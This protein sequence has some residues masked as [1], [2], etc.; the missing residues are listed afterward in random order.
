[1]RE[2]V[3]HSEVVAPVVVEV[4]AGASV[5]PKAILRWTPKH[6]VVRASNGYGSRPPEPICISSCILFVV[7]ISSLFIGHMCCI[8]QASTDS[9]VWLGTLID[10]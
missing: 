7:V 6:L 2:A 4:G 8:V 9:D 5:L 3:D 10:C 1:M